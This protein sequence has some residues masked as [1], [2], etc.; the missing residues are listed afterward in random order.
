[1]H[2]LS[3]GSLD[4]HHPL[5]APVGAFSFVGVFILWARNPVI[6]FFWESL[7]VF[8]MVLQRDARCSPEP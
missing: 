7:K 6:R 4:E 8:L 5:V 2:S 1:M 3:L